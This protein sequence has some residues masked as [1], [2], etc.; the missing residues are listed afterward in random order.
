MR[1]GTTGLVLFL[2]ALCGT[3]TVSNAYNT[4]ASKSCSSDGGR[5]CTRRA[6][7]GLASSGLVA[8]TLPVNAFDGAG[9]SAYSGR[10]PA[11]K[12]ELKKGWQARVAADVRDFNAL[13]EAIARGE[14]EGSAWTNFFI[15]FQRREPDAVGRTYAALADFRGLPT[16]DPKVFE[17]GDGFLLANTYTKSGKPPD[18]TPA[19]KSYNKLFKTFDAISAAG[20][21]NDA[22]KAKVEWEKT[23]VLLSQY[24]MD[25][26]MPADLNDPLYK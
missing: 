8:A 26:E 11:S 7:F 2:S 3:V 18:N 25:V 10:G 16:P 13:G 9:S 24:L 15:L 19:V 23:K 5:A 21:K 12:A 6:A 1:S 22:K 20:K 17:G 4:P 14:T